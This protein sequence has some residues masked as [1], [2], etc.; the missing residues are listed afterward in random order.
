MR[1]RTK[2]T[3]KSHRTLH[4]IRGAFIP[5]RIRQV[6]SQ[7]TGIHE[8]LPK[9]LRKQKTSQRAGEENQRSQSKTRKHILNHPLCKVPLRL[10]TTSII[11]LRFDFQ[12]F[13]KKA[14]IRL[15]NNNSQ[16]AQAKLDAAN[17]KAFAQEFYS[18]QAI[19][20]ELGWKGQ[21]KLA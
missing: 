5:K 1:L 14:D 7:R 16:E 12:Q 21:R 17:K 10:R 2:R 11:F 18:R 4:K 19:M 13:A 9:S 8:R 15:N 6:R 20:K 3:R